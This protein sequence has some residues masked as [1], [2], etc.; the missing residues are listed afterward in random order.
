MVV[1]KCLLYSEMKR[2]QRASEVLAW[3][4]WSTLAMWLEVEVEIV[5]GAVVRRSISEAHAP[6]EIKKYCRQVQGPGRSGDSPPT[7]DPTRGLGA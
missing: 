1:L 3:R 2:A 4:R 6:R 5:A 7:V